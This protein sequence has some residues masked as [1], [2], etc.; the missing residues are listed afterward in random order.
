MEKPSS[1]FTQ[2]RKEEITSAS[3]LQ[4]ESSN[5]KLIALGDLGQ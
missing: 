4:Y 1:H 5:N 3:V 2:G